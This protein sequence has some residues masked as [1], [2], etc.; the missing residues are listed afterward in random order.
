M[1]AIALGIVAAGTGT[2][3]WF[4]EIVSVAERESVSIKFPIFC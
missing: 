4:V 1:A 2:I 3:V